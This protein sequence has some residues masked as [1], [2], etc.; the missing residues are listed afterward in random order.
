MRRIARVKNASSIWQGKMWGAIIE[1]LAF[2]DVGEQL[3]EITVFAPC[4]PC[5][6][7]PLIKA[8]ETVM[9]IIDVRLASKQQSSRLC[10]AL[11]QCQHVS[12]SSTWGCHRRDGWLEEIVWGEG[13]SFSLAALW[14]CLLVRG[15]KGEK[16]LTIWR[17]PQK[18][19]RMHVGTIAKRH[20]R[21]ASRIVCR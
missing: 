18:R 11:P 8:Q 21:P 14:E 13:V 3:P 20:A 10:P 12:E 17:N 4:S 15:I 5:W 6:L 2:D 1:S 16:K 9:T 19:R 7:S